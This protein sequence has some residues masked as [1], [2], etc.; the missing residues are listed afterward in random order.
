MVNWRIRE[1]VAEDIP[2]ILRMIKDL[3]VFV[4][5]PESRVKLTREELVRDGFGENPWQLVMHSF[6][7]SIP[8][9]MDDV[10]FMRDLYVDPAFR[11]KGIGSELFRRVSEIALQNSCIRVD[12]NVSHGNKAAADFYEKRGG[13]VY[14][15]V[16]ILSPHWRT[17]TG[18]CCQGTSIARH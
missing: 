12:W 2:D 16:E 7:T 18:I 5:E 11:G 6:I 14:G 13:G 15:R 1:A 10:C 3:A 9:G 8:L 17:F 4:K